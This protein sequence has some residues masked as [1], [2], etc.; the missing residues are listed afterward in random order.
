MWHLILLMGWFLIGM[1]TFVIEERYGNSRSMS[2]GDYIAL[3]ISFGFAGLLGA[4]AMSTLWL[5]D[6]DWWK[7][8]V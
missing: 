7:E 3:L 5:I 8:K 4:L 2:R 6:T 1:I